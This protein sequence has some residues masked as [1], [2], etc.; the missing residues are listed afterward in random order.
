M[1]VLAKRIGASLPLIDCEGGTVPVSH[2]MSCERRAW[3][4]V[5]MLA[6]AD[7]DRTADTTMPRYTG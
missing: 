7:G 6:Q 3:W 1:P 2:G 5:R 4:V